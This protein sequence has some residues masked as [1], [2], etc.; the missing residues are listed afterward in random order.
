[1]TEA[2]NYHWLRHVEEVAASILDAEDR[3][4][5]C[6]LLGAGASLSSGAPSTA[7]ILEHCQEVKPNVFPTPESVYEKFSKQHARDR[8]ML[9]RPL[10][11]EVVPYAGYRCLVA[12]ARARPVF[13]VNL[14]W[15]N[16]LKAAG[17]ILNVPVDS[18][19]LRET[20]EIE[21]AMAKARRAGKGVV[22]AH[23]HGRLADKKGESHIR[24]DRPNTHAFQPLEKELL[25]KK[26]FSNFTIAIGTSLVGPR[27]VH[28][29]V[30][31]LLPQGQ[32][33]IAESGE[34]SWPDA[35]RLWIFER[36]PHSRAPGFD[37]KVTESLSYALLARLSTDNF[38]SAPDIDF[39]LMLSA[40]RGIEAGLTWEEAIKDV[41]AP[42]PGLETLVPPN[43]EVV[44]PILDCERLVVLGAPYVGTSTLAHL[45][46]WWRCLTDC[47]G[48]LAPGKLYSWQGVGETL[49]ILR[50][51]RS[52]DKGVI[53][54]DNLFDKPK[55]DGESSSAGESLEAELKRQGARCVIG[56]AAPD[57]AA[58]ALCGESTLLDSFAVEPVAAGSLWRPADLRAWARASGGE[59]AE[60]VCRRVRLGLDTTPAQAVNTL[61]NSPPRELEVKWRKRL[62][63][64]LSETYPPADPRALLLALLRLQDFSVPQPAEVLAEL[65][66]TSDEYLIK[67]PWGLCTSIEV[68][69][70]RYLRLS[71]PGVVRAVDDWLAS[72]QDD[73]E[74]ALTELG[75]VGWWA[76]EALG[77][78]RSFRSIAEAGGIPAEFGAEELEL[79]GTE[80]VLQALR[81]G[82]PAGAL[83][84]L[85]RIWDA[86]SDSWTA[87]DVALD[88]VLHWDELKADPR[89]RS[90][91]GKL[92][93]A[94][95]D[96]G[97]YALFE[98]I[99]RVG[100]PLSIELWTSA[101]ARL[102]DLAAETSAD[103]L[104]RKQI[105]LAFDALLWRA[106]P[107]SREDERKLI[108]ALLE[109]AE[110]DR[111]LQAY[112]T[113]ACAYHFQGAQ[114]LRKLGF[115]EL[116]PHGGEGGLAEA[117]AIAWIVEWHFVH[118]S[119][120]RAITSRRTFLST[121]DGF[122]QDD[123]P[124]Y[125]DR[126]L[127]PRPLEA[128]HVKA[129]IQC[130]DALL[131]HEE[132]AGWA[133][134]LIMNLQATTGSFH[135]PGD[136]IAKLAAID[137]RCDAVL[138]AALT[139]KPS[140]QIQ[141]LLLPLLEAQ[142][143]KENLQSRLGQGVCVDGVTVCEPRF[144]MGADP[145]KIRTRWNA[146]PAN[147]PFD[148]V[149]PLELIGGLAASAEQV[150][151]SGRAEQRHV[152]LAL[153]RMR[154][155]DTCSVEGAL[156]RE[157]RADKEG[158]AMVLALEAERLK[159]EER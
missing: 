91:R 148:I 15:D 9:I 83:D 138:S 139:Y 154:R 75:E 42:L 68:D 158:F 135:V 16:C 141:A 145:W 99:L 40:L 56:T 32:P 12:L 124:R 159:A 125:L 120:C 69:D 89:A 146:S 7:A 155:G 128:E 92:L 58:A 109:A 119:R 79:F 18:F 8:D 85:E 25:R 6:F 23:V 152:A 108:R 50:R 74:P 101:V 36:G 131:A 29:M 80:V 129:A 143:G 5:I 33:Q 102:L 140:K 95:K 130:I 105:A 104:A 126:T 97:A 72:G 28:E 66:G 26:F 94:D 19:D 44:R 112:F 63:S 34:L 110:K 10:F 70:S 1:M 52:L 59:R 86:H 106:C 121:V 151:E 96:F 4:P 31:A 153:T 76:S 20:Q 133:L 67:D 21:Q 30:Q 57:G 117:K 46:A 35:E 71:H 38:I 115:E 111:L 78:W 27:D 73:L 84:A 60:L 100:R 147:L 156:W 98:A 137:A 90:L 55:G 43:P 144:S 41:E 113:A 64:H 53:V 51:R 13:V 134:H 47:T 118:Q 107:A 2:T 45:L 77:R 116:G 88:L 22:C 39:D 142:E 132:T 61:E 65:A 150:V 87:K 49:S 48:E 149:D 3:D 93:A 136:R 82:S 127:H 14:N 122:V 54:V 17:G 157:K 81:E 37:S 11:K 24:F 62:G 114:R 123:A 103:E